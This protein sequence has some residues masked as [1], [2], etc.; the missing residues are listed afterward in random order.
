[1]TERFYVPDAEPALRAGSH[2]IVKGEEAQHLLR[3]KRVRP[4]EEVVLFDGRGRQLLCRLE[5]GGRDTASLVVLAVEDGEA[6]DREL[7]VELILAVSPPKGARLR[8][9][10]RQL[11]ELGVGK[12]LPLRAG[13]SP[14]DRRLGDLRPETRALE[15]IVV[16]AAKQCGRNRLLAV[17]PAIPFAEALA[18]LRDAELRLI[19]DPDPKGRRLL[20]ALPETPPKRVALLIG[21]EGGFLREERERAEAAGFEG[22]WLARATLRI[23]TAAAYGAAAIGLTYGRKPA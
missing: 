22:V 20:D 11:T 7:P 9:L 21:P 8:D 1:M 12:L 4:G 5:S 10:V 18:I 16:E 13:R 3:V 6:A 23:E 15:R 19:A 17:E 2:A 14:I